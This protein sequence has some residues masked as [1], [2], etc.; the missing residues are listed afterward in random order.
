MKKSFSSSVRWCLHHP[1]SYTQRVPIVMMDLSLYVNG[2]AAASF[3]L[4]YIAT[5]GVLDVLLATGLGFDTVKHFLSSVSY[6]RVLIY[7]G[8]LHVL[9]EQRF[10]RLRIRL[11]LQS[12][13]SFDH[14]TAVTGL[15]LE[16]ALETLVG[17]HQCGFYDL[18][19][20]RCDASAQGR[21]YGG[22]G[23]GVYKVSSRVAV[24]TSVFHLSS[25]VANSSVPF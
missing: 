9:L 3:G 2:G 6:L 24:P 16:G 22:E 12:V 11:L 5:A 8:C 7:P 21:H 19:C 15:P 1:F 18:S 23:N 25:Y 4:G 13:D 17:V 14:L 10:T 20:A